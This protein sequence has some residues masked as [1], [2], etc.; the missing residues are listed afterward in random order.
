MIPIVIFA[1]IAGIWS[2]W[3]TAILL[4]P[5]TTHEYV[6]GVQ[7]YFHTPALVFSLVK[8]LFFGACITFIACYMGLRAEGGAAGVGRTVRNTVVAII[9]AL[10]VLD[11]LLAPLYKLVS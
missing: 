11:V 8:G 6:Y 5:M 3:L 9:V 4:L 1:N 10:M 7:Q 2:G